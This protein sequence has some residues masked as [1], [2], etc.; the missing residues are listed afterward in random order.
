MQLKFSV[1]HQ[2][3]NTEKPSRERQRD[4]SGKSLPHSQSKNNNNLLEAVSQNGS[5]FVKF[6]KI[7][8]DIHI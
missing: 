1:K 5:H 2:G 7:H 6:Y 3:T 8:T 4:L